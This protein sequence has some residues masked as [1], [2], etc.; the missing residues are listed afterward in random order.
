MNDAKS[1]DEAG[2]EGAERKAARADTRSD[3]VSIIEALLLA[4]VALL[5]GWSGFA[6]TRWSTASRLTL[7]RSSGDRGQ[8]TRAVLEAMESR[9]FD[10]STFNAWF[11]AYSIGNREAMTVAER[12]FRPEFAV[13][14][15]AWR[16]TNPDTN[17][18]APKGPTYMPQYKQPDAVRAIALDAK[19]DKEH[20]EGVRAAQNA[21]D[22]A[23]A[24]VYLATVLFLVGISRHFNVR[25]ARYGLPAVGV[26]VLIF[27]VTTLATLPGPPT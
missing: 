24:T 4:I 25:A 21:N 22:Y 13:A 14:F 27:A 17:A 23:R 16:A 11:A 1:E 5:V 18:N 6:S 15:K 2:E 26:V 10:A 12:R 19:A 20:L 7:A 9:N 8:A 3:V